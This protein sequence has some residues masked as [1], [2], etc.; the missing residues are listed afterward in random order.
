MER[1]DKDVLFSF[2]VE[3]DLPDLL[4]FCST[5][6]RINDLI[7]KRDPIWYRKLQNDFPEY[8][9]IPFQNPRELYRKLYEIQLFLKQTDAENVSVYEFYEFYDFIHPYTIPISEESKLHGIIK[10]LLNKSDT[11]PNGQKKA[12]IVY[13]I[14]AW[15]ARNTWFLD[16]HKRF[17]EIVKWKIVQLEA[18]RGY[19]IPIIRDFIWLKDYNPQ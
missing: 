10:Q 6:S 7:C 13:L 11:F 19:A 12:S 15:L 17:R 18:E 3:L 9:S 2:A 5:H 4:A 8:R 16:K 14:F 1:L